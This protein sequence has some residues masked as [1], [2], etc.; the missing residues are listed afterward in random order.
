MW[1]ILIGWSVFQHVNVTGE[2]QM[3]IVG[4]ERRTRSVEATLTRHCDRCS[5]TEMFRLE[6]VRAWFTLFFIPLIPYDTQFWLLCSE[7]RCGQKLSR[8]EHK[9]LVAELALQET[10]GTYMTLTRT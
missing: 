5:R 1:H 4:W 7:C 10:Q 9:A 3:P 2:R 6:R 8:E